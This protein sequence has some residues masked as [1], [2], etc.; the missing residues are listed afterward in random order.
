MAYKIAFEL[1]AAQ[2]A[3]VQYLIETKTWEFKE[4]A[5]AAL[6]DDNGEL[7]HSASDVASTYAAIN[8]EIDRQREERRQFWSSQRIGLDED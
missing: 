2:W 1:D 4:L 6:K 8:A 5:D 3:I 7:F